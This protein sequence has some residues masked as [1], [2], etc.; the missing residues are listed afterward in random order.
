MTYHQVSYKRKRWSI[1]LKA[2]RRTLGR[3]LRRMRQSEK[4]K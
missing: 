2:R 4:K 3:H 1:D